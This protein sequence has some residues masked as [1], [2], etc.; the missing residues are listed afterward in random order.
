MCICGSLGE[1]NGEGESEVMKHVY[2]NV[3]EHSIEH[4]VQFLS[5]QYCRYMPPSESLHRRLL[6]H[7]SPFPQQ[8][9][10]EL[11]QDTSSGPL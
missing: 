5:A 8:L 1:Q 7:C 6:P 4:A 2:V 10:V 3:R 11:P 9:F